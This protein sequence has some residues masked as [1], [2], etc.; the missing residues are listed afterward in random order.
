VEAKTG[1]HGSPKIGP[2]APPPL[3]TKDADEVEFPPID[4]DVL[5]LD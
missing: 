5:G 3:P 2:R 4:D 1:G